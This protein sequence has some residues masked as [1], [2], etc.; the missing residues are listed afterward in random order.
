[1]HDAIILTYF[2]SSESKKKFWWTQLLAHVAL[3]TES[4]KTIWTVKT[5][6]HFLLITLFVHVLFYHDIFHLCYALHLRAAFCR[7]DY[8]LVSL[9]DAISWMQQLWTSLKIIHSALSTLQPSPLYSTATVISFLTYMGKTWYPP[10]RLLEASRSL[11]SP[12]LH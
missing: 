4:T 3:C 1:M 11:W 8:C 7:T 2:L 10:P 12:P 5:V 9:T 6:L